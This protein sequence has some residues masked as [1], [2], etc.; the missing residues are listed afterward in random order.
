MGIFITVR[1]AVIDGS[2]EMTTTRLNGVV[3]NLATTIVREGFS[4]AGAG[5]DESMTAS[6]F[7]HA[8]TMLRPA[9][10]DIFLVRDGTVIAAVNPDA[11]GQ[12]V[13]RSGT[14]QTMLIDEVTRTGKPAGSVEQR[15]DIEPRY[16]YIYPV[17]G[18]TLIV[19]KY[20]LQAEYHA[21]EHT[22]TA[23][24]RR[25]AIALALFFPLLAFTLHRIVSWPVRR[26]SEAAVQLGTGNFN[27]DLSIR[28]GDEFEQLAAT[29]S[30]MARK[31]RAG[32]ER[33]LSPQV[34]EHWGRDPAAFTLGGSRTTA[35]IMFCDLAGFTAFS[36][37]IETDVLTGFL[38]RYFS[39]ATEIIFAR[40][41]TLDKFLGDGILAV[42][43]APIPDPRSAEHAFTAGRMLITTFAESL[44][45]WNVELGIAD[46]T[47]V[48]L[49]VG[50]AT[51]DV[52][53]GNVGSELRADF[54][55]IG[56]VVNLASRLESANKELETDLL[57]DAATAGLLM[58]VPPGTAHRIRI[59]GFDEPV[60]VFS[61]VF[62][63]KQ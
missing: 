41:G 37:R 42:F 34:V 4:E 48:R 8:Q 58:D 33:Y 25:L 6:V 32:Y 39:M 14:A 36:S 53:S 47:T 56:S 61:W 2:L 59:R 5:S 10:E 12:T 31:I 18:R 40:Q 26:L 62:R 17:S 52:Y 28:S 50:L 38:N 19:F 7:L 3:E 1:Q 22:V 16:T 11:A 23:L 45:A 43:G 63:K 13:G 21:I 46:E 27:L 9:I 35:T 30:S 60:E 29:F 44:H 51:G 24:L 54:T 20:S 49:R 55:V 15:D 57:A